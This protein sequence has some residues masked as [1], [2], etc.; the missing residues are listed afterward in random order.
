MLREAR[1]IYRDEQSRLWPGAS[2]TNILESAV[3]D[4]HIRSRAR[5]LAQT[6]GLLYTRCAQDATNKGGHGGAHPLAGANVADP[7]QAGDKALSRTGRHRGPTAVPHSSATTKPQILNTSGP[8]DRAPQMDYPAT[9]P[10]HAPRGLSP[11]P[12]IYVRKWALMI[13]DPSWSQP[14]QRLHIKMV[15]PAVTFF[16]P[17][18]SSVKREPTPAP[19]T[20]R[21]FPPRGPEGGPPPGPKRSGGAEMSSRGSRRSKRWWKA[22]GVG[23]GREGRR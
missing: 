16:R 17:E 21:R 22:Q 1:Q 10:G 9:L 3:P 6:V 15:A 23:G 4:A 12:L 2:A 8:I 5:S 11:P 20:T 18:P 14:C 19:Q 7:R 13:L